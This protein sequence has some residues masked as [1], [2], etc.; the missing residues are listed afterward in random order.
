MAFVNQETKNKLGTISKNMLKYSALVDEP[1]EKGAVGM[2]MRTEAEIFRGN[3]RDVENGVFKVLVM[4]KFKNGKSTFVNALV[5][6]VMM[7]ARATACTAV[8]ATVEYGNDTDNVKVVY[9][10][11]TKPKNMSLAEFTEEFALTEE[12]QEYIEDGGRIDRFENVSHVEMQSN[13][14]IFSDGVRLID[15]PGLEEATSRTR[16]T[17]EFVPKANAIIFTLSATSLFSAAE[18]EYIAANFA[19]KR[20]RNVFFVINRIDNLTAGQLEASVMPSVR[21]G[22]REVFTDENGR[23]DEEL[24]NKRVFFTNAYGALCARTGEPY[25]I[26]LGRDEVTVDIKVE[27][28]GMLEFEAALGEFLNSPD[29]INATFNS[30][31]RNMANTYRIAEKTVADDKAIRSQS[32]NER[33]ENAKNAKKSLDMAVAE[34][35]N[36]RKTVKDSAGQIA[37]RVYLDL[38]DYVQNDIPREF[39]TVAANEAS[40]VKFGIGKM[41]SL[42]GSVLSR[43]DAKIEEIYQPFVQ[44]TESYIKTKL[45]DWSERVPTL[46]DKDLRDLE[47]ELNSKFSDFDMNLETAVNLFAYGNTRAPQT[48]GMGFKT[49]LQNALALSNWDISLAVEN[50]AAGGMSWTAFAKK[51]AVQLGIDA[52]IS[53]IFGAPLLAVALPIELAQMKFKSKKM[54]KD[55]V[56]DAGDK[57]FGLLAARIRD[58]ETE[59]KQNIVSG[60][61]KK[62]ENIAAT[63]IKLVDDQKAKMDKLL[64]ENIM[65]DNEARAEDERAERTLSEMRGCVNAI[66]KELY[67]HTPTENEFSALAKNE[68]KQ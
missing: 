62:G 30:A 54:A 68:K 47:E 4:G 17:N 65:S 67:G 18:K 40:Q 16:A 11:S 13:D 6:K 49:G 20:M 23:F 56:I 3:A 15:S 50:T 26:I 12:D 37:T 45:A 48:S 52:G 34:V 1:A 44:I 57:A 5:G 8:I 51:A 46:I 36:I 60:Y 21:L 32:R 7:A 9:S 64:S 14:R 25:K 33:E 61:E 10:D 19:G 58:T 41:M 55:I 53:V 38:C 29:R 2:G 35:E 66:Y 59:F 24:Y 42:A 63:A 27:S 28:T 31:L 22:L 43:N 39:A